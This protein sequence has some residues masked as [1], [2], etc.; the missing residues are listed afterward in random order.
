[1]WHI[2]K[3]SGFQKLDLEAVAFHSGKNGI[4]WCYPQMDPGRVV[5]LVKAGVISESELQGFRTAIEK[6][7]SSED[8]FFLWIVLMACGE[9]P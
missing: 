8:P 9:K 3:T 5:P 7:M 4:E 6:F 2:L 1:L